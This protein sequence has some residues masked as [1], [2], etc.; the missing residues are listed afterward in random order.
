MAK[1]SARTECGGEA[2]GVGEE[3]HE[4]H[5]LLGQIPEESLYAGLVGVREGA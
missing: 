3:P 5:G 1:V 4:A 2:S